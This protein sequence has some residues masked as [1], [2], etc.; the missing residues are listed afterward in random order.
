[1]TSVTR[2][3]GTRAPTQPPEVLKM[4]LTW[5]EAVYEMTGH[6]PGMET[7]A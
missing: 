3:T 7:F 4:A 5:R 1:M 6:R 2:M